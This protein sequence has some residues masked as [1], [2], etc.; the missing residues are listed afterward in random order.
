MLDNVGNAKESQ[1]ARIFKL[2]VGADVVL[3]LGK[4]P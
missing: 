4:L 1:L 2:E 3:V